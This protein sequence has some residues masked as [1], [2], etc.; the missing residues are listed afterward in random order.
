MCKNCKA[1][2]LGVARQQALS[3]ALQACQAANINPGVHG[4]LARHASYPGQYNAAQQAAL[5]AYN[6]AQEGIKQLHQDYIFD[7]ARAAVEEQRRTG[8][9]VGP[10]FTHARP[11]TP[12]P[13]SNHF[14]QIEQGIC[15]VCHR[16]IEQKVQQGRCVVA[17]PCG[18]TLYQGHL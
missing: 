11:Q 16:A 8:K 15:P 18:D 3:L 14:E 13:K 4:F 6:A 12:R 2:D 9:V 7:R 17:R 10:A 1:S 5:E